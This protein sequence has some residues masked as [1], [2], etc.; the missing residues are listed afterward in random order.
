MSESN[1]QVQAE[2][3]VNNI[4]LESDHSKEDKFFGVKTEISTE[5][6]EVEVEVV[7]DTPQEDRRPPKQETAE[8]SVDD[9]TLDKEISDY[10]ER[11]GKRISKI[12]YE[13]HEERRAKEAALRENSEAVNRLKT[14]MAENERLKAMVDQG[15]EALNKQALNNAQWA[16]YN[17]Q[18]Q[19]K[20][21]YDEGDADEMA[22]AQ[23][24]L[25][26][27]TL[28][29]QQ[30][31][32]YA[33]TLQKQVPMPEQPQEQQLDPEMQAW[34]SKNTWFMN[35]SNP[36]HRAMTAYAMAIDAELQTNGIDPAT[37]SEKYYSE[38]DK[39]MKEKY[40]QFFGA[41][42]VE[43]LQEQTQEVIHQ[44]E[45]PKR[46]PSNVVA[47]ATRSTG[48]KPRSIRLTQTQV[49]LAKQ[50]GISPEQYANQLIQE[51]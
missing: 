38:V 8:E 3:L 45:A 13:Y 47:P 23:E 26:R 7:D 35:N 25:S 5:K 32:N 1:E 51:S 37:Q 28:A 18:A 15:G 14:M 21:A 6:P 39:G 10:S 50:L 30:A 20:K 12:K 34:S 49:R 4:E 48:K 33:E 17:A 27:A 41:T 16:K 11:A 9:E 31:S 19:F 43:P 36:Q 40:P 22:K 29:E 24:L 2:E 44:E 46:Q 42:A